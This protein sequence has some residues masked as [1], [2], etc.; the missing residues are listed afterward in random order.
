MFL[1]AY[2]NV[3]RRDFMY[4]VATYVTVPTLENLV[5]KYADSNIGGKSIVYQF[6]Y[7]WNSFSS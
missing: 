5:S 6:C 2:P 7:L 1:S 3:K 4:Y